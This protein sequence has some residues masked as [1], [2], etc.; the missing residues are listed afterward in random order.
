MDKM[1]GYINEY[2]TFL[3]EH[4]KL[5]DNTL[6]SYKRDLKYFGLYLESIGI[7]NFLDVSHVDI[8]TYIIHLKKSGK[9]NASISRSIASIRT[10][11][12]Y[13]QQNGYVKMNP[14]IE[15]ETPKTERKM[16]RILTLN[17]V[18]SLLAKPDLR[19]A[20]GKRDKA[21]I[22]LLYAT[23]I[24][25]S[26]LV[27]LTL[28]DV[29][30]TMGY[31]KCKSS[32]KNRVIPLGTMASKAIDSYLKDGRNYLVNSD[33]EALFVN[34]YGKQ[35]TRQGFWKVMKRYSEEIGI[36]KS[37]TPHTLRHSFAFHLVQNGADIKAVQEMMGHSDVA[38]TQIYLDMSNSKLRDIYEKTH[39]R[40]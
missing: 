24:R 5:S 9:A 35:L 32:H 12:S 13:L 2:E 16:P 22:E 36:E 20:I 25:V 23:G 8:M 21:M 3:R 17:E 26:E 33:E 10:Y 18:E 28:S 6:Q 11:Y 30:T 1:N 39:P 31:I 7:L 40:A 15:V 14:S 29:N 38:S 34:Y 19:T 27:S 37:I 4:K